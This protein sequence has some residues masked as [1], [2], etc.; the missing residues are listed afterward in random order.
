MILLRIHSRKTG[1]P[2]DF[3]P[4]NAE[5]ASPVRHAPSFIKEA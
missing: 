1:I 2:C 5:E 4:L 3:T